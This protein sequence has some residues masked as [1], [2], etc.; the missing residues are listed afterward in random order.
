[1]DKPRKETFAGAPTALGAPGHDA[2]LFGTGGALTDEATMRQAFSVA[3]A[4]LYDE[5]DIEVDKLASLPGRRAFVCAYGAKRPNICGTATGTNLA[6]SVRSAAEDLQ[7]RARGRLVAAKK[8]Q[9]KLKIDV[10]TQTRRREFQ[11]RIHRPKKRDVGLHGMWVT[12]GAASRQQVAYLLPSEMLEQGIWSPKRADRGFPRR[13]VIAALERR[14]PDLAS[15]EENFDYEQLTTIAW[16]ERDQ[17]EQEVPGVVRLFRTH[18]WEWEDLKPDTL[19]QFAVWAG[20]YLLSSV[21]EDGAIR[22]QYFVDR[23]KDSKSYNWLR[24]GGTTYSMLQ[25][26]DRTKFKPYL[27]AAEKAIEKMLG[28]CERAERTGFYGGGDTMF[29]VSPSKRRKYSPAGKRLKLGGTGLSL[30]ALAT[31]AET[32]GQRPRYL[33]D[34][35]A[36]ARFIVANQRESGEFIY[37][38][39]YK[40]KDPQDPEISLYYP[41]EAMLG[42]MKLYAMDPNPL[43][44]DTVRRAAD[45]LIDV[46]DRGKDKT[47]LANDH[48][49]M[50][51]L[52]YLYMFTEEQKYLDHS[53]AL[54]HAVQYQYEKRVQDSDRYRDFF[55]GYYD[56]PRS[57]PAAT[58]AEGMVAVLDSCAFAKID[59]AWIEEILGHTVRHE[60]L[61]SYQPDLMYWVRNQSKTLGAF[62]GGLIDTSVR[63]DFVQHNMS[64]VLGLERHLRKKN[65]I[66][67]P[68]G[69]AWTRDAMQGATFPGIGGARMDQLRAATLR[70]RGKDRWVKLAASEARTP[71]KPMEPKPMEPK[72][73]EPKPMEP[74]PVEPKPVEPKPV[75]PIPPPQATTG[76]GRAP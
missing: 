20:D 61:S 33:D 13:R 62:N 16:V 46:R 50:I 44:L 60:L 69:P 63:N 12:T 25:L 57:T 71:T 22:Y 64:A 19:L 2:A 1:M 43:W 21:A 30:L 37:F 11:G 75:E 17:P 72:P 38:P 5:P 49:L 40:K 52:S 3:R 26:Y 35:R 51:A 6:K 28:K 54:T 53:L 24:H 34:A 48:W 47:K 65:G 7:T 68:G 27:L 55:G 74:K 18:K 23:D 15:L 10:V 59:C 56:P 4:V 31:H 9:L 36:F 39:T 32:T 67:L 42:L 8:E 14:N 58:R 73:M 41:G 70:Y 66:A 45:W 76:V 29:L